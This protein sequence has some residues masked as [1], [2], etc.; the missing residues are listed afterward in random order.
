MSAQKQHGYLKLRGEQSR[1]D[2]PSVQQEKTRQRERP[3]SPKDSTSFFKPPARRQGK[4]RST[5]SH[6]HHLP[7][8]AMGGQTRWTNGDW[9]YTR[10]W[11]GYEWFQSTSDKFRTA[12]AG[13]DRV[14]GAHCHW[15]VHVLTLYM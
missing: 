4:D 12:T 9:A 15:Y 6:T 13:G 2:R 7:C 11:S 14:E 3:N 8:G 1:M 5:C 10:E